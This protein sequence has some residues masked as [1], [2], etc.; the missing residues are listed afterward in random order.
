MRLTGGEPTLHRALPRIVAG[1]VRLGFEQVELETNAAVASLPGVAQRLADAGLRRAW[2]SVWSP[3]AAEHD[4]VAR[5]DGAF[6]AM[7]AGARALADAGVDVAWSVAIRPE[8]V[9]GLPDVLDLEPTPGKRASAV[10]LW[11]VAE[12]WRQTPGAALDRPLRILAARARKLR[13]PVHLEPSA[14]LPP[15]LVEAQ[16][17]KVAAGLFSSL[18]HAP[19]GAEGRFVR[20]AACAE[21]AFRPRCAGMPAALVGRVEALGAM[22]PRPPEHFLP[23]AGQLGGERNGE[24]FA[25]SVVEFAEGNAPNGAHSILR[26]MQVRLEWACNQ[27][28]RFCWVDFTWTPLRPEAVVEALRQAYARGIDQV[29]ITGGEPTLSPAL[30]DVVRAARDLGFRSIELQTNGIR[31]G[32]GTL[33]TDLAGAGLTHALVSL[34]AADAALSDAITR[35][36]GT[37]QRTVAGIDALV[38]AGVQ[39]DTSCVLTPRNLDHVRDYVAFVARRWRRRV[40]IRWAVAHP[41]TV[42]SL[43]AGDGIPRLPEAAAALREGL[44]ACRRLRVR[45]ANVNEECGVPPCL[46]D[47]DPRFVRPL[48]PDVGSSDGFVHVEACNACAWRGACRGVRRSYVEHFGAAG[49]HPLPDPP[50][51]T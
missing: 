30:L 15:C 29:A 9:D 20:V 45:Y 6:D 12:A 38:D 27:R 37:W 31:L 5:V 8:T 41:I 39:V 28:C 24:R 51:S 40:G 42:A 50:P 7:R 48:P 46:L 10:R 44:L 34:H 4:A 33:A 1:A 19:R 22:P 43:E 26:G 49:L 11:F 32:A 21:C 23:L 13:T 35:A 2:V 18:R 17:V 14:P 3:R 36:P 16:T 47:G 25:V